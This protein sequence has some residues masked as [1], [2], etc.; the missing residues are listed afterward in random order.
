MQSNT[1]QT[2][3]APANTDK[4]DFKD[5]ARVLVVLCNEKIKN[6]HISRLT[7]N[8]DTKEDLIEFMDH[9]DELFLNSRDLVVY[10]NPKLAWKI[11]NKPDLT[12]VELCDYIEKWV[13][14]EQYN[15]DTNIQVIFKDGIDLFNYYLKALIT[16]GI[17]EAK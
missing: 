17:Y 12:I 16:A 14:M 9:F 15:V 4:T 3:M 7:E 5:F 11:P 8:A 13:S 6:F 10:N 2:V 1:P